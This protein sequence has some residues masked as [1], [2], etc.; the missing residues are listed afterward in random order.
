MSLGGD[1]KGTQPFTLPDL[2]RH[3]GWSPYTGLQDP[4]V[5]KLPVVVA[6]RRRLRRGALHNNNNYYYHY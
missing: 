2:R 6:N 5:T 3:P 4:V 1:Q